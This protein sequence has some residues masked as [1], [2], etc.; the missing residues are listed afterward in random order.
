MISKELTPQSMCIHAGESVNE[1]RAVVQPIYQTSTF[2]FDSTGHG[3]ALFAGRQEGYIYTRKKIL[4]D[5][6]A[7]NSGSGLSGIGTYGLDKWV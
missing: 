3:A 7:N 4:C 1:S 2:R 5:F 6:V